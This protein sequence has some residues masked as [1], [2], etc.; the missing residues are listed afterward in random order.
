MMEYLIAEQE[1]FQH[2][3]KHQVKPIDGFIIPPD[4]AGVGIELNEDRIES[5]KDIDWAN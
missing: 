1:R 4:V 2:F 3:L 5:E